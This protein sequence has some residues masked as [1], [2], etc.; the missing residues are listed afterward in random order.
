M[1]WLDG[2]TDLMDLSLSKLQEMVMDR[3][4]W[5]AAVHG[6]TK[7]RTQ[8]SDWTQL[9]F[10]YLPYTQQ[11]VWHGYEKSHQ[12][13]W[14]YV[15]CNEFTQGAGLKSHGGST[16]CGIV[17][18]CLMGKLEEAFPEIALNRMKRWRIMRQQ[19]GYHERPNKPKDTYYFFWVG[20]TVN[21][22]Y[23]KLR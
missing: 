8:L 17:S 12:L 15:L 21:F 10:L 18:L 13:Y 11:L 4:A 23:S 14:N 7:Y 16:F 1:R 20:A 3:E 5:C 2:I 22:Q 9:C 19:N 6:I